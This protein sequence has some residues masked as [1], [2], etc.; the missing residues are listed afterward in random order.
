M[1]C[2]GEFR[3]WESLVGLPTDTMNLINN[4]NSGVERTRKCGRK[5]GKGKNLGI[6]SS[7]LGVQ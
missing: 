6:F 7:N 5:I 3:Q 4:N 2:Q 1:E